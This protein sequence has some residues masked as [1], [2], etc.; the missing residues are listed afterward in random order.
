MTVPVLLEFYDE[1]PEPQGEN[2]KEWEERL[3]VSLD[4][5][6][7]K[8]LTRYNEGTLQRVLHSTDA[9]TRR[10]SILAIGLLGSMKSSN[11]YLAGM[12]HDSDRAVRQLAADALWSL[13]FRGDTEE[14][15]QE[16]QRLLEIRDR[17]KKRASLDALIVRAPHF[18]E[19]L[20]QRAILHFQTEEWQKSIADC[21]RVLK[22]NPFHFGAAAGMGRAHMELSKHKAALKAFR[23]ALRLNPNLDDVEEAIRALETALGEEGKKDDRK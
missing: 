3:R 21:E 7:T 6:K 2:L 18:A 13:W 4:A 17:R 11:A 15:C 22:L 10:A 9:R 5:F 19:A 14:N 12:L 23:S 20:N 16:L 8:V 1:L